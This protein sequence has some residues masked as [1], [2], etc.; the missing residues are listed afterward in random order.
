MSYGG[1]GGYGGGPV[2][3]GGGG[4][5]GDLF[6]RG[7]TMSPRGQFGIWPGC[8]CSSLLI[9]IAG[10]VLVCAGGLRMIGQ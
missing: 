6:G 4:I 9:V 8:G 10:I 7:G 3:P 1:G 2:G 5:F